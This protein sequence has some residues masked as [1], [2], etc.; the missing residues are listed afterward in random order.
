MKN[1]LLYKR[2]TDS[3]AKSI[4]G[5]IYER[6]RFRPDMKKER[7]LYGDRCWLTTDQKSL[8][9]GHT[10]DILLIGEQDTTNLIWSTAYLFRG[11]LST[12]W[13]LQ[14]AVY[15]HNLLFYYNPTKPRIG[16]E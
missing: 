15:P 1:G 16:R 14:D 4:L 5:V 6:T 11:L 8:K 12:G 10:K 7:Q 9:M 2:I 3:P 13:M